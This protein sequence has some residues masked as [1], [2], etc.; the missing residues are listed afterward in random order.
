MNRYAVIVYHIAGRIGHIDLAIPWIGISNA[1]ALSQREAITYS[2]GWASQQR[3]G[4]TAVFINAVLV[5]NQSNSQ[6]IRGFPEQLATH[7]FTV[8]VVN[9]GIILGTR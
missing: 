4:N 6:V 7:C 2:R 9:T 1:K 3:A 8:S 5:G